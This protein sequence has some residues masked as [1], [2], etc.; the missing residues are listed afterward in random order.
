[1]LAFDHR[2]DE[3]CVLPYD[4]NRFLGIA[5]WRIAVYLIRTVLDFHGPTDRITLYGAQ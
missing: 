4:P 2:G 1:V 5:E 3:S